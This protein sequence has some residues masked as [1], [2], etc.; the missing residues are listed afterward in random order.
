MGFDKSIKNC[1]AWILWAFKLNICIISHK[2]NS[3]LWLLAMGLPRNELHALDV[4][5]TIYYIIV[6]LNDTNSRLLLPKAEFIA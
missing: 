6:S 2:E 5:K 3:I 1:D 4:D